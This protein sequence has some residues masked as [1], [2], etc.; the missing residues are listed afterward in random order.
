M[1]EVKT[2]ANQLKEFT[3]ALSQLGINFQPK[4]QHVLKAYRT[5]LLP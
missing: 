3:E 1:I 2:D 5:S 4:L